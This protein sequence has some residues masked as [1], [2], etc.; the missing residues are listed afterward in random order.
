MVQNLLAYGGGRG[1]IEDI[2]G[3]QI[4]DIPLSQTVAHT[5]HASQDFLDTISALRPMP[6]A[7][8]PG[9]REVSQ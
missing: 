4:I 6:V 7:W 1:F 9:M 8:H 5:R 2:R 3:T